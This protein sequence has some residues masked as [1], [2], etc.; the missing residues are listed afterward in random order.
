MTDIS[1]STHL[2]A[3][4]A[5]FLSMGSFLLAEIRQLRKILKTK[6]TKALSL[7][8]YKYKLIAIVCSL[9]CFSL[10]ALY[11]SFMT[12]FAEGIITIIIMLLIKKY[13]RQKE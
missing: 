12:I 11:M 8:H 5:G 9:V 3:D 7:T 4:I 1:I 10:T 6:H 2:I 13:R